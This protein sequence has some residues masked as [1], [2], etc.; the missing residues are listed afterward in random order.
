VKSFVTVIFFKKNVNL[1]VFFHKKK[2]LFKASMLNKCI[3]FFKEKTELQTF[4][5]LFE[6]IIKIPKP[7]VSKCFFDRLITGYRFD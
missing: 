3:N 6:S 7:F 4:E 1:Y 5:I 2:N